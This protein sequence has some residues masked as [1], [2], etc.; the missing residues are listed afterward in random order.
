MA[1]PADRFKELQ[2]RAQFLMSADQ[3]I[4]EVIDV[5]KD[6]HRI[7]AKLETIVDR[8][9]STTKELQ[10]DVGSARAERLETAALNIERATLSMEALMSALPKR[11]RRRVEAVREQHDG[12]GSPP[13]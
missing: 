3:H 7:L 9:D 5:L 10:G 1:G 13:A 6:T 12:A 11:L 2:E 8:L 4:A